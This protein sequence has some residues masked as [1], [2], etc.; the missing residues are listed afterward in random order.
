MKDKLYKVSVKLNSEGFGEIVNEW[1]IVKE[2]VKTYSVEFI[3]K[4]GDT[5]KKMKKKEQIGV[6]D[7]SVWRNSISLIAYSVW[8]FEED[9]AK[10][11]MELTDMVVE[12]AKNYQN[13]F[14]KLLQH[15]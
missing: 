9:I 14:N 12:T 1:T 4:W 8:C 5:C 6:I 3:D 11:K 2:G 10:F 15:I 13:T 7:S